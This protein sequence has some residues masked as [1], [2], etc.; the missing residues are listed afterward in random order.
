MHLFFTEAPSG[1]WAVSLGKD[2]VNVPAGVLG[3]VYTPCVTL[4]RWLCAHPVPVHLKLQSH[5]LQEALDAF[6][7]FSDLSLLKP[8]P[9]P[10]AGCLG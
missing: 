2:A 8:L 3:A 4:G 9:G 1:S 7:H 10:D 6:S 5:L